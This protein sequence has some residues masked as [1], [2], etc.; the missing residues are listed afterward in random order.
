MKQGYKYLLNADG[1]KF[2]NL[3]LDA[4][5]FNLLLCISTLMSD[6]NLELNKSQTGLLV[7]TPLH[8]PALPAAFPV[9][10]GAN[11]VL[12]SAQAKPLNP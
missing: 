4:C 12:P 11:S 10:V 6:K 3:A 2:I 1:Y 9:L 7:S 8:K 5:I